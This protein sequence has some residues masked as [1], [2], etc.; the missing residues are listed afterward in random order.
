M[1]VLAA[2]LRGAPAPY[3]GSTVA[4]RV[5]RLL[6]TIYPARAPGSVEDR[7][8]ALVSALYEAGPFPTVLHVGD[9][10]FLEVFETHL[11]GR[12]EVLPR[13][14]ALASSGALPID[15]AIRLERLAR[16]GEWGV[17]GDAR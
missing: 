2:R 4:A 1:S 8:D 14:W 13:I 6:A 16:G 11:E 9:E 12:H 10:C 3:G 5:K 15:D 7:L 17:P